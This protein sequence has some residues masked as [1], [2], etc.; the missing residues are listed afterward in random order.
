MSETNKS[1]VKFTKYGA[2]WCGPCKMMKPVINELTA[3]FPEVEFVDVDVDTNEELALKNNVRGIPAYFITVDD[4]IVW[5][6]VGAKNK[7]IIAAE[8]T[9]AQ[10]SVIG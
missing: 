6:D 5:R 1:R 7:S 2:E 4:N 9:K 8:L 3:E 10:L